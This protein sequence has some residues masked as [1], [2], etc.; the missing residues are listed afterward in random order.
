MCRSDLTK[1]RLSKFIK[2]GWCPHPQGLEIH[3]AADKQ[4]RALKKLQLP[5]LRRLSIAMP[6]LS[7][8]KL[9]SALDYPQLTKLEFCGYVHNLTDSVFAPLSEV[10]WPLQELCLEIERPS[11]DEHQPDMNERMKLKADTEI[12]KVPSHFPL[13]RKLR[14][15]GATLDVVDIKALTAASLPFLQYIC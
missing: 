3:S 4:L 1:R 14:L 11:E 8:A 6:E 2:I 5:E 12:A 10:A 9:L 15:D 13:L 7:S